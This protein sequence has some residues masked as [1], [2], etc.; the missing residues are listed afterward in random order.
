MDAPSPNSV[1]KYLVDM[2]S[3][4]YSV[5]DERDI[6]RFYKCKQLDFRGTIMDLQFWCQSHS[7][8]Q[9]GE[10]LDKSLTSCRDT[11]SI[12]KSF[13]FRVWFDVQ[14]SQFAENIEDFDEDFD[15]EE[16]IFTYCD[17]ILHATESQFEILQVLEHTLDNFSFADAYLS[18]QSTIY[19]DGHADGIPAE[20][21]L[22]G[23]HQHVDFQLKQ[24]KLP[25]EL[26]CDQ[27]LR[28]GLLKVIL[29]KLDSTI[30]ISRQMLEFVYEPPERKVQEMQSSTNI[31][32][33]IKSTL[34][35]EPSIRCSP[36]ITLLSNSQIAMD[37]Q[38]FVVE[39]VRQDLRRQGHLEE[40]H[41]QRPNGD[42][43][44]PFEEAY[45]NLRSTR[46]MSK[47]PR[48]AWRALPLLQEDALALYYYGSTLASPEL[49]L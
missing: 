10:K 8:K 19:A 47:L 23:P 45:E 34:G 32:D 7:L 13:D 31:L 39:I 26:N 17:P 5:L 35:S 37:V 49:S 15:W 25:H 42:V 24:K 20:D 33:I 2:A 16:F 21:I 48:Q 43:E 4:E 41:S 27:T 22:L 29:A 18:H 38:T 1:I 14:T 11:F 40:L 36:S 12:I 30:D 46:S 44:L 6:D 3:C 28:C 9:E